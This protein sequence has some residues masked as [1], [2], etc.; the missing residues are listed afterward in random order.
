[1]FAWHCRMHLL[2]GG[3][4]TTC[5]ARYGFPG[6]PISL[7]RVNIVL[8][9]WPQNAALRPLWP[10]GHAVSDHVIYPGLICLTTA[11]ACYVRSSRT[12]TSDLP[13][14]PHL[15]S[16]DAS[17]KAWLPCRKERA[18]FP[19]SSLEGGMKQKGKKRKKKNIYNKKNE[20]NPK[21][22]NKTDREISIM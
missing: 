20:K 6:G 19:S 21:R 8:Q 1:M 11:L 2:W 9:C 12:S 7:S 16:M 17:E 13:P 22:I 14:P 5:Q 3:H 4:V 10:S 15:R 18:D